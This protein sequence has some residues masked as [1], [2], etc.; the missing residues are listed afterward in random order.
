MAQDIIGMEDMMAIYEV[1]DCY[2]IDRESISVPLEKQG[3]GAVKRQPS[4]EIEVIAPADVTTREWLPTLD[5]A[6]RDLGFEI[7][8]EESEPWQA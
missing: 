4:G 5:A 2:G 3:G 6:L 7:E 8:V 1:T